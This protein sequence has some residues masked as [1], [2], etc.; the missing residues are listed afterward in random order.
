MLGAVFPHKRWS[1][2]FYGAFVIAVLLHWKGLGTRGAIVIVGATASLAIWRGT[3]GR[4]RELLHLGAQALCA[5][6]VLRGDWWFA[7]AAAACAL[8]VGLLP[9]QRLDVV[10]H[11]LVFGAL[12]L[13]PLIVSVCAIGY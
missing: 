4:F 10:P 2:L 1:A 8:G 6:T 11:R 12:A 5:V 9:S 7:S 3:S 13:M